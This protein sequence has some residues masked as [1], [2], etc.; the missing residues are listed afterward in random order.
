MQ[1][2]IS[3]LFDDQTGRP[4]PAEKFHPHQL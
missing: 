3:G 2:E 4:R 1:S